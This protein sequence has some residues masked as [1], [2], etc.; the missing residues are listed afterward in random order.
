MAELLTNN[1][2]VLFTLNADVDGAR[3]SLGNS[4]YRP[5]HKFVGTT[6][7]FIGFVEFENGECFP[8]Q[9]VSAKVKVIYPAYLSKKFVIS[10]EWD[11]LEG[12]SNQVGK[13]TITSIGAN[14]T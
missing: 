6:E 12:I 1:I 9:T 4:A 5:N 10:S 13:V 14:E 3:R 8:G 7:T 11:V 2:N